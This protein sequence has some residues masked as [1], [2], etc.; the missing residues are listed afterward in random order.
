[1][2]VSAY[3]GD[4]T[5]DRSITGVGFKPDYVIVLSGL[6]SPG[7]SKPVSRTSTMSGEVSYDFNGGGGAAAALQNQIQALETNRVSRSGPRTW[8]T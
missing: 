1:M 4:G 2:M 3:T 8:S 7:N 5:D 6:T